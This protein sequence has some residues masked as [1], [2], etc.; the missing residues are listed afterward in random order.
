MFTKLTPTK[1]TQKCNVTKLDNTKCNQINEIDMSILELGT[2]NPRSTQKNKDVIKFPMCS[3]CSGFELIFRDWS[4]IPTSH[5]SYR[6]KCAINFLGKELKRLGQINT[7]CSVEIGLETSDPPS[8]LTD[9]PP[10][11]GTI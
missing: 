8:I 1:I 6:L 5:P 9:Y 7:G 11:D 2:S 10:G 3:N 4:V